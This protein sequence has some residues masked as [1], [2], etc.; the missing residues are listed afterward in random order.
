MA[1]KKISALTGASTPLAGTEVLPIV[2]SGSTVK[3]A[4]SDL[5]L[6]RSVRVS[7]LGVGTTAPTNALDVILSQTQVTSRVL[8]QATSANSIATQ[9]ISGGNGAVVYQLDNDGLGTVFGA[10]VR[11][12]TTTNSFFNLRTN[13]VDRV[14]IAAAGD[15]TVNTGNLVIGTTAKGITTGSAIP[16]GLGVNNTVTAM[17]I[18]TSSNVAIGTATNI[19][20]AR[21]FVKGSADA[22]GVQVPSTAAAQAAIVFYDGSADYTGQIQVDP[23]ANSTSYLSA[24]DARLKENVEDAND[25]GA[26][27][28]SIKVRQFDWKSS[29]FHQ[30]YGFVAQELQTVMPTAVAGSADDDEPRMAVDNSKLVPILLKEIQ[31]LRARVA[32]LESA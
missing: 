22:M 25:A 12:G 13:N 18:D 27:I 2:Q 16:L 31:S 28:D 26:L 7:Q 21:L 20:S 23:T 15:V 30:D 24:S 19:N 11:A 32:Q 5:T 1:D 14:S 9:I 3:V 29:G 8:N 10:G 6:G 17:S 4:V